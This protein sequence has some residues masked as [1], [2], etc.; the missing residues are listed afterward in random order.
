MSGRDV[1]CAICITMVLVMLFG[2]KKVKVFPILWQQIKVF[3]NDKSK[4]ISAWDLICFLGMPIAL[5]AILTFGLDCLI[6]KELA[7][8][9]TTVFSFVFTILFG[10]AAILV[11]KLNSTNGIEKRVVRETFVS[12]MTCT[13]FALISAIISICIITVDN[14]MA[15]KI[16][17]FGLL[18][19]SLMMIMLLLLVVKRTFTVYCEG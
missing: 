3:Q 14:R 5:G 13:L 17:S 18:C 4:K 11:S 19:I 2:N 16:L 15:E 8:V 12:L 6:D 1:M 9:L 10:F 7:T